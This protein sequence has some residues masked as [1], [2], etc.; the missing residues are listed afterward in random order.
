[1]RILSSFFREY[2]R[3]FVIGIK[4]IFLPSID[5]LIIIWLLKMIG[6]FR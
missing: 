1:M 4:S 6:N 2:R 5:K 3:L